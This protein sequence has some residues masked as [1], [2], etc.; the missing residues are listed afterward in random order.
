[1]MK[2]NN[3]KLLRTAVLLIKTECAKNMENSLRMYLKLL[4]KFGKPR[5]IYDIRPYSETQI[6]DMLLTFKHPEVLLLRSRR[7]GKTRDMTVL[8]IFYVIVGF[9][10]NWFSVTE[11]QLD[12]VR[13][14]FELNPFT[15]KITLN[16]VEVIGS[17][18]IINFG[19]LSA[20]Q[21]VSKGANVLF[22][23]ELRSCPK[24]DIKYRYYLNA[25]GQ[26]AA[27]KDFHIIS[28]STTET[29][30]A[31][32]DQYQSLLNTDPEAIS[33]HPYT[34]F[35]HLS[36]EF[37]ETERLQHLE[38]PWYVNQ[39]YKCIHVTRGGAVF[40][41]ITELPKQSFSNLPITHIGMDINAMEM[42]VGLHITSN[43]KECY[44]LFEKTYQ[45]TKDQEC[46]NELRGE[47]L[48]YKGITFRI[49][50]ECNIEIENGGYN[51][52][53]CMIVA[54]KIDATMVRW[55]DTIKGDRMRIARSMQIFMNRELTP[56]LY[57]DLTTCIYHPLKPI[58]LKDNQHP[59]HWTDA[60]FHSIG[61]E[62]SKLSIY[63]KL[64]KNKSIIAK[65]PFASPT[66][67][68]F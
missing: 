32:H 4:S 66:L 29:G 1:M 51:E 33:I 9:T 3:D 26:L 36:E 30:S 52:K 56:R 14:W 48:T 6:Q 37:I 40:D 60:F 12:V 28:G 31:E 55:D 46:F 47:Y 5:G 24:K 49:H 44:V 43:R 65:N 64:T 62:S 13:T 63:S 27:T 22:F 20:G 19:I 10:V 50:K 25:R 42:V 21:S 59:N 39:E 18:D 54:P 68:N 58:Y 38:D 41:N 35:P 34:D 17:N 8:A 67:P 61:A 53:E 15:S 11:D 7:A 45:Y 2:P 57:E 16:M 23:D